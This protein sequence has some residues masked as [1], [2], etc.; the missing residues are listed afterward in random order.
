M[1]HGKTVV[2]EQSSGET[3]LV[4]RLDDGSAKVTH[5]TV[6]VTCDLIERRGKELLTQTLAGGLDLVVCGLLDTRL[7]VLW[8]QNVVGCS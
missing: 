4:G 8:K 2:F 3:H 1:I 5:A 6:L 7:H